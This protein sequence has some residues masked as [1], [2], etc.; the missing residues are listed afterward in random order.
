MSQYH[1]SV[2]YRK[3]ERLP[4]AMECCEVLFYNKHMIIVLRDS[5]LKDE[6]VCRECHGKPGVLTRCRK[7]WF[8]ALQ[9]GNPIAYH[10][11]CHSFCFLSKFLQPDDCNYDSVRAADTVD[12]LPTGA[13]TS[14]SLVPGLRT[15]PKYAHGGAG[16]NSK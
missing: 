11:S 7:C 10:N 1:M 2:A 9:L 12:V 14:C 16:R 5:S 15:R 4:D 8:G 3:L 6:V 13:G